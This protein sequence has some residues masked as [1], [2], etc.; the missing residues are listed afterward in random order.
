MSVPCTA[1]HKPLH[2]SN[3]CGFCSPCR[4]KFRCPQCYMP[5]LRGGVCE[6][7]LSA[8]M[9]RNVSPGVRP[10]ESHREALIAHYAARFE[11]GLPLW[12]DAPLPESAG[13]VKCRG[14]QTGRARL[15]NHY[16]QTDRLSND[17]G[18]H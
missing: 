7:C 9:A 6:G 8:E 17:R 5:H 12:E 11:A 2:G 13:R 4:Q 10:P 3:Q 18:N 16:A 1:C 14:V 15:S